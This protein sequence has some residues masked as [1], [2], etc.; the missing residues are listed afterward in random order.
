MSFPQIFTDPFYV[1]MLILTC[2]V[3]ARTVFASSDGLSAANSG[4]AA[5]EKAHS[6][7]PYTAYMALTVGAQFV[8]IAALQNLIEFG[9]GPEILKHSA[10]FYS[11]FF[12]FIRLLFCTAFLKRSFAS[13]IGATFVML[14]ANA[15][16]N[17]FAMLLKAALYRFAHETQP[18]ANFF[19]NIADLA[20]YALALEIVLV[21]YW[22]RRRAVGTSLLPAALSIC[23]VLSHSAQEAAYSA[24]PLLYE[25][26]FSGSGI[27][28][29]LEADLPS[30][31]IIIPLSY[32][33]YAVLLLFLA[34]RTGAAIAEERR[35]PRQSAFSAESARYEP[36]AAA[37]K[38][39]QNRYNR[40]YA[41]T[42][43]PKERD[44]GS[45][46]RRSYTATAILAIAAAL[47]LI[48]LVGASK[49]RAVDD[50]ME[51]AF[52][53]LSQRAGGTAEKLE[54][55]FDSRFDILLE[56]AAGLAELSSGTGAEGKME[57][58]AVEFIEGDE[59]VP[60]VSYKIGGT[61][62]S[63]GKTRGKTASSDAGLS[64]EWP[65]NP[66]RV[67]ISGVYEKVPAEDRQ[68]EYMS[69]VLRSLFSANTLYMAPPSPPPPLMALTLRAPAGSNGDGRGFVWME[70]L[71]DE[72]EEICNRTDPDDYYYSNYGY[73]ASAALFT[74]EDSA[75][76]PAAGGWEKKPGQV[77]QALKNGSHAAEGVAD[78]E[79]GNKKILAAHA[80]RIGETG[81][82]WYL[83]YGLPYDYVTGSIEESHRKTVFLGLFVILLASLIAATIIR[84]RELSAR[85]KAELEPGS[86]GAEAKQDPV[87]MEKTK[88]LRNQRVACNIICV[89]F[90]IPSLYFVKQREKEFDA[91]MAAHDIE[92][93]RKAVSGMWTPAAIGLLMG[94]VIL[95]LNFAGY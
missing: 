78:D 34:V 82:T 48:F 35:A 5:T 2:L 94:L 3:E 92:G 67:W 12:I 72:I 54:E 43:S 90:F 10:I 4:R 83:S 70:L 14:A 33:F 52:S 19:P 15:A 56:L 46:A 59:A 57:G 49:R 31:L 25:W 38:P 13:S 7:R 24:M 85:P 40:S 71:L 9:G 73:Y 1:L 58:F 16:C 6:P 55:Y 41:H 69:Q 77:I 86:A 80:V 84:A 36:P 8:Y 18:L 28:D 89:L 26:A 50:I 87:F 47:L 61:A 60:S 62:R 30:S 51:E 39:E 32:A 37:A 11:A 45:A 42:N 75:A 81:R 53:Q 29:I 74:H 17:T 65:E 93:M 91:A 27:S 44:A 20:L 66:G 76:V 22:P 68:D 21:R 63:V 88:G 79:W 64:G 23:V 95:W